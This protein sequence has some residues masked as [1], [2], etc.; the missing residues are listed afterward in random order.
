M[1]I[2]LLVCKFLKLGKYMSNVLQSGLEAGSLAELILSPGD[3][4]VVPGDI[5]RIVG[6]GGDLCVI[7]NVGR[8][9][10]GGEGHILVTGSVDEVISTGPGNKVRALGTITVARA[11]NGAEVISLGEIGKAYADSGGKIFGKYIDERTAGP[12]STVL[13]QQQ[14]HAGVPSYN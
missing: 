1:L 10:T 13:D 12:D 5:D 11:S 9:S 14:Q 6:Y 4:R 8:I 7:G 2:A 3:N